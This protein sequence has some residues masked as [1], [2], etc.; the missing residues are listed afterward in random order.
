MWGAGFRPA[1]ALLT[2]RPPPG[3]AAGGFFSAVL[4]TPISQAFLSN[5]DGHKELIP[6]VLV[7]CLPWP[8]KF[9]FVPQNGVSWRGGGRKKDE[10]EIAMD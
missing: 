4:P 9:N 3:T 8:L 1:P 10:L 7:S 2:A 6:V 5:L